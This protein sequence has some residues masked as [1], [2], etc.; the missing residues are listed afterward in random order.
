MS[1]ERRAEIEAE[2]DSS[3]DRFNAADRALREY[4]KRNGAFPDRRDDPDGL[5]QEA[6]SAAQ[7]LLETLNRFEQVDPNASKECADLR[8]QAEDAQAHAQG[9]PRLCRLTQKPRHPLTDLGNA[10]RFAED[11]ADDV[12][13][14]PGVAW[15]EWDGRR[16]RSDEDGAIFRRAKRT[17]RTIREEAQEIDD[18]DRSEKVFKH[19]VKSESA[20]RINAMVSLAASEEALVERPDNLDSDP[21]LLNVLN[22]TVELRTGEARPHDRRDLIT[23]LA[24]VDFD[25]VAKCPRWGRFLDTVFAGNAEL[26]GF[27][28]RS[29]GYSL[30]GDTREQCLFLPTGS[31]ANGKST[32]LETVQAL[33]GDYGAH[34]D[35]STFMTQPRRGV[36]SDV[37]RLRGK[38]F[39]TSAEVEDD[40]RFAEVLVKQMTGGEKLVASRLY[41]NEFEFRPTFKVWIAAN[42]LPEIRGTDHAIWRRL[43]VIPFDV[44]IERPD[45]ALPEKLRAEL[46]GILNWA[47]EGA[48]A[49]QAQ[50]LGVPG[51]VR[52][53]TQHY[54]TEQDTVSL[55]LDERC[56]LGNGASTS[57]TY[58]YEAYAAYCL[59]RGAD[60][61][62]HRRLS[63]TLAGRGLEKRHTREGRFW[64]GIE[65]AR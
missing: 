41:E 46:P 63:V 51:S 3:T 9:G 55:F 28:Q 33:V 21:L 48:L 13:Y 42:A 12:H 43:R 64:S 29:L 35:A 65:V 20:P 34:A 32:L 24:R 16:H 54:R 58:M 50:G 23:S 8:N 59:Q 47:I 60:P 27:V 57:S 11:N 14:V 6:G 26:I 49:W 38:R 53:A 25:P 2:V 19:A 5:T 30:T 17:V 31:G 37:A 56:V 40:A 22:G 15:L 39:V 36:R 45:K 1:A 10:E 52:E 7:A 62:S 4:W 18:T 44:K 61:V